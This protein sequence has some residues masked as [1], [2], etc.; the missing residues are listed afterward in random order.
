MDP[1]SQRGAT[2]GSVQVRAGVRRPAGRRRAATQ[3]RT[4]TSEGGAVIAAADCAGN[5]FYAQIGPLIGWDKLVM[6]RQGRPK[7]LELRKN[8]TLCGGIKTWLDD[9]RLPGLIDRALGEDAATSMMTGERRDDLAGTLRPDPRQLGQDFARQF[10]TKRRAVSRTIASM[11]AAKS[12]YRG[13]VTIRERPTEALTGPCLAIGKA[14]RR[15]ARP[16]GPWPARWLAAP[17]GAI[18]LHL[19]D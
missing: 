8:P 5:C 10:A 19:P 3:R 13:A 1:Q 17:P 6:T 4:L 16:T 2:A 11:A 18:L 7:A 14:T 9:G 15:A 12:I